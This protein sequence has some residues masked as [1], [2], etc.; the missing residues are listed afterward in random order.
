MICHIM[1]KREV[2][3]FAIHKAAGVIG[4]LVIVIAEIHRGSPVCEFLVTGNQED[5]DI[6][7]LPG[8]SFSNRT[9]NNPRWKAWIVLKALD[10][11]LDYTLM[12]LSY[13]LF[14]AL[15]SEALRQTAGIFMLA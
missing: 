1:Q 6:R 8:P 7:I 14:V 11:P 4:N 15:S 2:N 9:A 13:R 10:K 3:N 5:I 12:M